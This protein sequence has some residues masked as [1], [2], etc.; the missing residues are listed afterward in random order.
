MKNKIFNQPFRKNFDLYEIENRSNQRLNKI[1]KR[2]KILSNINKK[3]IDY[4]T[5]NIQ[6]PINYENSILS[7]ISNL[8]EKLTLNDKVDRSAENRFFSNNEGSE[9]EIL[10]SEDIKNQVIDIAI[11]PSTIFGLPDGISE[12]DIKI[13][14]NNPYY[15]VLD[16]GS[17]IYKN[18]SY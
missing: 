9:Y 8:E 7:G 14:K 15:G 18:V 5:D 11:D 10:D 12:H 1:K 4:A 16:S 17:L 3:A 13:E 6:N 2:K